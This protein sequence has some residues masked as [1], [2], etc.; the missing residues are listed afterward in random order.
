[1]TPKMESQ[2]DL[3]QVVRAD[4]PLTAGVSARQD[5]HDHRGQQYESADHARQF[6]PREGGRLGP[7]SWWGNGSRARENRRFPVCSNL[8]FH[9]KVGMV[10]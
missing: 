9:G 7:T 8:S 10:S 6:D 3:P 1:M 5:R 4:Y 2:T